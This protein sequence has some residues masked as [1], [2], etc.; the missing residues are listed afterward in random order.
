MQRK[1]D[2]SILPLLI[3]YP[4]GFANTVLL[5]IWLGPM[6]E[7]FGLSVMQGGMIGSAELSCAVL[8]TL[9]MAAWRHNG[10]TRL[11]L[12]LAVLVCLCANILAASTASMNL[13]VLARVLVGLGSGLILSDI[14]RRSAMRDNAQRIFA[15]QQFAVVVLAGIFFITTPRLMPILGQGAA[16]AYMAVTC[17]LMLLAC[18]LLKPGDER[19][20]SAMHPVGRIGLPT[21]SLHPGIIAIYACILLLVGTEA[22]MWAYLP[23]GGENAGLS[24]TSIGNILSLGALGSLIVSAAGAQIGLRFG[25]FIPLTIGVGLM[26]VSRSGFGSASLA[27][28]TFCALA[29][30][31]TIIF[32]IPYLYSLLNELDRSGRAVSAG[33]AFIVVGNAIAPVAGAWMIGL[34]GI[35]MLRWVGVGGALLSFLLLVCIMSLSRKSRFAAQTNSI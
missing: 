20:A 3:G 22:A 29:L 30:P 14:T 15:M 28:F 25:R 33:P 27:W 35:E 4:I 8:A 2:P 5:P 13:F 23:R 7:R 9:L 31:L 10:T 26:A 17:L 24:L 34:G 12:V 18:T 1:F 11:P 6:A 32:V 16:F 21:K 19:A